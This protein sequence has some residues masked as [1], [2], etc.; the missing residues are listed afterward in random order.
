MSVVS[1]LAAYWYLLPWLKKRAFAQA[2]TPLLLLHGTRAV[3]LSFLAPAVRGSDL[4]QDLALTAALGDTSAALLSLFAAMMVRT[5]S[6]SSRWLV[7]LANA[8]GLVDILVVAVWGAW[9]DFPSMQLGA[10]WFI[11][12]V[13]GPVML[14]THVV[15][16]WLLFR[17]G[18]P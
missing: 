6:S 5:G 4:P 18:L 8:V 7:F 12:T 14:T 2:V 3:G 16:F 13:L 11:P 10:T 15:M 9:V 1:T 17:R